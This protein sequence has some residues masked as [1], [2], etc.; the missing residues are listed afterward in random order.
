VPTWIADVLHGWREGRVSATLALEAANLCVDCGACEAFCHEGQ[1][2]PA[3]IRTARAELAPPPPVA[4]LGRLEGEGRV[5]AVLTD[6]RDWSGALSAELGEPVATLRTSDALGAS[7]L[8]RPAFRERAA[9]LRSLLASR[10]VVVSHGDAALVLKAADVAFEWLHEALGWSDLRSG[11]AAVGVGAG[12][13]GGAGPLAG[14]HPAD[15]SR[16]ATRWGGT[17]HPVADSRCARHLRAAIGP[18]EDAVDRLL[19]TNTGG[20]P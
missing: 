9:M 18:V 20:V 2:L 5:V 11:C 1:P 3:A 13:C 10:R 19:Q 14:A 6:A 8:G 4:A 15:A 16:M 12:C 17:S 7:L